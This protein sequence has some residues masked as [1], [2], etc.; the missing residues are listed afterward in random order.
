MGVAILLRHHPGI[1]SLKLWRLQHRD[2]L[3]IPTTLIYEVLLY[4]ISFKHTL[5]PC[6]VIYQQYN[7]VYLS[8]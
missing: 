7:L 6:I 3:F 4:L 5:K 2:F 1:F 8:L